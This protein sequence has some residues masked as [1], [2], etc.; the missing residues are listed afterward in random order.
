MLAMFQERML[1]VVNAMSAWVGEFRW[2]EV[3][4]AF[5]TSV[6]ALLVY[7]HRRE[8]RRATE[9]FVECEILPQAEEPWARIVIRVRN[10]HPHTLV[11]REVQ[12]RR[13]RQGVLFTEQET[14]GTPRARQRAV[15]N[16]VPRRTAA[17]NWTIG[18]YGSS[19]TTV[20]S[21][22]IDNG[23]EA[24]EIF[25]FSVPGGGKIRLKMYLC[26]ETRS[27]V[28]R[29]FRIP[30]KRTITLCKTSSAG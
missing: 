20:G 29:Q 11:V 7:L 25:Y 21:L 8:D 23:D 5:A 9:P 22:L 15:S 18:P 27:R 26:C 19:P 3:L 28:I 30:I 16:E 17:L 14:F 6:S 13:P 4:T 2:P 1:G 24:T 12:L 10:F